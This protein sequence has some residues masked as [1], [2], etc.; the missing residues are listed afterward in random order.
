MDTN[1]T[2]F[3]IGQKIKTRAGGEQ[4]EVRHNP[5]RGARI[6][7]R[8]PESQS[9][10]SPFASCNPPAID[11]LLT[12]ESI[13]EFKLEPEARPGKEYIRGEP[14]RRGGITSEAMARMEVVESGRFKGRIGC[15]PSHTDR[16]ALTRP[17]MPISSILGVQMCEGEEKEEGE[18]P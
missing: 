14:E 4:T 15:E 3:R 10:Q 12:D 7:N 1:G 18:K 17:A 8:V 5:D 11:L 13:S 2:V 16:P 9:D 6:V